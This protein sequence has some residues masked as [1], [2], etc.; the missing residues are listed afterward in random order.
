MGPKVL[1]SEN[2]D[3]DSNESE[4]EVDEV[5]NEPE[6]PK[7]DENTRFIKTCHEGKDEN[8][9]PKWIKLTSTYPGEPKYMRLRSHPAALRYHKYKK[10]HHEFLGAMHP[11]KSLCHRRGK[12]GKWKCK[13]NPKSKLF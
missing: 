2:E 1:H 3:S 4:N 8:S 5:E 7:V 13:K 10:D 6:V 11:Y 12:E 9:L